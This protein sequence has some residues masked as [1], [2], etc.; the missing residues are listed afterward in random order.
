[1]RLNTQVLFN[2]VAIVCLGASL[3]L[4]GCGVNTYQTG[5]PVS[6]VE[7]KRCVRD[8]GLSQDIQIDAARLVD[9]SGSKLAQLT[10]RN[11]GGSTRTIGVKFAWFDSDGVGVG[12]T[13]NSWERFTLAPG[14]VREISSLGIP[15]A[16]DFR[17]SVRKD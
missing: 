13:D 10:I 16:A 1:M 12:S 5:G 14:E 6:N 11:A 4:C 8:S 17:V 7:L 15:E 9:R 2:R 3:H